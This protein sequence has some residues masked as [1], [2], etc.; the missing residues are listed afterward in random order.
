[1]LCVLLTLSLDV[2]AL[3]IA[4]QPICS[5]KCG[6]SYLMLSL[7]LCMQLVC[8]G[9]ARALRPASPVQSPFPSD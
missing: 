2:S 4:T 3:V 5:L 8:G 9:D 7:L 6:S 1:M